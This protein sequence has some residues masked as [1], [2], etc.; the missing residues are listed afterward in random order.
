MGSTLALEGT[1]KENGDEQ[2]GPEVLLAPRNFGWNPNVPN[3]VF[4]FIETL[5]SIPTP[6]A[7]ASPLRRAKRLVQLLSDDA[8][9]MALLP[10]AG[11]LFMKTLY[12]RLDG[13]SA[14]YKEVVAARVEEFKI[15]EVRREI[16]P[17]GGQEEAE[18]T[19]RRLRTHAKDIDRDTSIQSNSRCQ[20][21]HRVSRDA[22]VGERVE[23]WEG[24][25]PWFRRSMASS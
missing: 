6:D 20:M 2:V 3:D 7:T 19:I 18:T 11:D 17:P 22:T 21:L 1:G 25:H 14:E 24:W 15:V 12:A 23:L 9:G 5:P 16:V 13:L 10:D 4:E 8:S